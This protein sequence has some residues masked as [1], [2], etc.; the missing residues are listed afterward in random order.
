M[1]YLAH[2]MRYNGHGLTILVN[3]VVYVCVCGGGGVFGSIGF[4]TR[5]Q[6]FS[7]DG[8]YRMDIIS[9]VNHPSLGSVMLLVLHTVCYAMVGHRHCTIG[10]SGQHQPF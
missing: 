1:Q 8:H 10:H 7:M 4:V 3:F 2:I 5:M 6:P 9:D